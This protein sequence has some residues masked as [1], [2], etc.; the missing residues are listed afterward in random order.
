MIQG[1]VVST[2]KPIRFRHAYTA[3]RIRG[4]ERGREGQREEEM[5]HWMMGKTSIN[6]SV[7]LAKEKYIE[8]YMLVLR[9]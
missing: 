3:G 2:H 4:A 8:V 7:V 5:V 1:E 9:Y 6:N